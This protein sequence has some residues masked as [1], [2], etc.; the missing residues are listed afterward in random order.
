MLFYNDALHMFCSLQVSLVQRPSGLLRV[1]YHLDSVR[2]DEYADAADVVRMV[3]ELL[4]V[5]WTLII[6]AFELAELAAMARQRKLRAYC[7][8]P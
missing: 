1:R 5:L 7:L 2:A 3:L 4:L 8:S 6:F